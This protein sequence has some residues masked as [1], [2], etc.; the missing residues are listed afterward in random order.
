M[1]RIV[2]LALALAMALSLTACGKESNS[3]GNAGSTAGGGEVSYP[4]GK[5]ITMICPWSAGGGSDNGVRL[6]VPYL[7]KEL[8]TTITVI[9]PTGGSG[10]VCW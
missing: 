5:T 8:D 6:L 1:K 3:S 9:N 7:E 4:N 10:W 2:A